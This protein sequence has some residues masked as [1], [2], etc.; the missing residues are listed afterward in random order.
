LPV[1]TN[2]EVLPKFRAF[3]ESEK[4]FKEN[5]ANPL[6]PDIPVAVKHPAAQHAI[7][8]LQNEVNHFFEVFKQ[9][10]G[11][12][13]TNPIFGELGYEQSIQLLHKHATHH[14]RQFGVAI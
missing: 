1:V 6:M 2:E 5:T 12:K 7:N 14:L 9:D 11:K 3:M 10:A 8:E 4:P 13:V